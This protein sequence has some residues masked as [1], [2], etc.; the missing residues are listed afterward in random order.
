VKGRLA[1]RMATAAQREHGEQ[2]RPSVA[3]RAH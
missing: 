3:S 1:R 2:H